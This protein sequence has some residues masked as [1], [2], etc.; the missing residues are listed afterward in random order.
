MLIK[1]NI[2][3][4]H[5]GQGGKVDSQ[6]K[7]V[8]FSDIFYLVHAAIILVLNEAVHLGLKDL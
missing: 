5:L 3:K 2:L 4:Y 1:T 7:F 8:K 6:I